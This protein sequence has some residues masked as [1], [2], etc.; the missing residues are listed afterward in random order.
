MQSGSNN[1]PVAIRIEN[2]KG[3]YIGRN[4]IIGFEKAIE[5]INSDDIDI[6]D[7]LIKGEIV[8]DPEE[9]IKFLREDK[10][11]MEQIQGAKKGNTKSKAFLKAIGEKIIVESVGFS[12]KAFLLAHGI[13]I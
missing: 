10:Y 3:G 13:E 12:Y 7:N 2:S 5:V 9:F 6:V 4:K 11:V 8:N 1:K